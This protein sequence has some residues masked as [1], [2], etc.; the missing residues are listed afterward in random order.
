MQPC[1][2]TIASCLVFAYVVVSGSIVS[3]IVMIDA[4]L[5]WLVGLFVLSLLLITTSIRL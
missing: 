5:L 2:P 4:L 1:F 3:F